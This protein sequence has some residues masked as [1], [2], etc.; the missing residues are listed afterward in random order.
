[1]SRP[2]TAR[3]RIVASRSA[4]AFASTSRFRILRR[5]RDGEV[6]DLVAQLL[7]RAGVLPAAISAFAAAMIRSRF[8]ARPRPSP[9]SIVSALNFSPGRD[10]LARLGLRFGDHVGDALLGR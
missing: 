10:D 4:C 3:W 7:A 1:M 9:A 5:A 2:S 8:G 6:G